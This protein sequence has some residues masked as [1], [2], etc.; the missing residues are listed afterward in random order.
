MLT[1]IFFSNKFRKDTEAVGFQVI[2]CS[3]CA[4]KN[5][6]LQVTRDRMA[7]RRRK[8]SRTG[9]KVNDKFHEW[10]KKKY[11]SDRL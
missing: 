4:A 3:T 1:T 11:G 9:S 10:I 6:E 2:P 8:T 5:N 7:Y